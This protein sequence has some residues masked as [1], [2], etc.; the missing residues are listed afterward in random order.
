MWNPSSGWNPS[1]LYS[2]VM[3]EQADQVRSFGTKSSHPANSW[4]ERSCCPTR[5]IVSATR[6]NLA[7]STQSIRLL[8]PRFKWCR[9]ISKNQSSRLTNFTKGEDP[10]TYNHLNISCC[11]DVCLYCKD[12]RRHQLLAHDGAHKSGKSQT[13]HETSG[14]EIT[15]AA[16]NKPA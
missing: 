10:K 4:P 9:V 5:S 7:T 2:T 8:I 12:Y 13:S 14:R 3:N 16:F 15:L 11:V 1:F 6:K